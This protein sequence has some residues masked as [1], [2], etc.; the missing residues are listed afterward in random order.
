[1]FTS[2]AALIIGLSQLKHLLGF[3]IPRSHHVHEIIVHAIQDISSLHWITFTIGLGGIFLILGLKKVHKSIPGPLVAVIFGVGL[4]AVL[5][6]DSSGVKIVGDVPGGLP[7]F[8]IPKINMGIFSDLLPAALAIA[9]VSFME[10]IAVA[11]AIQ[12]KHKSY[13]VDPNKELVALGLSNVGGS[14][15]QSYPVTGG[16]SRTAV[17]DQAGA[18]TGMSSIISAVL[19]ILTLLFLTPLFYYL[20]NAILASVIMVAVFGLIDFKEAKHL[21]HSN[22]SDFYMLLVTFITTLAFGIEQGIAAGVILSLAVV[23]FRSSRPHTAV[24]GRVPETNY[25]RNVDRF[26]DLR[27]REDIL[28]LRFDAPLYFANIEY[29]R[30]I[31]E[32]EIREKG[33]ELKAIILPSNSIYEMDSSAASVISDLIDQLEAQNIRLMFSAVRGPVRDAMDKYGLIDKIG[34]ENF[35][36]NIQEAVDHVNPQNQSDRSGHAGYAVQVNE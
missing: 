14:F 12:A 31:F 7:S 24:L 36:M 17:N 4:V 28:I 26:K 19:I 6:L 21:W 27:E 32:D 1:G 13:K 10:S 18:R 2:A 11:K 25:Y 30:N 15:L 20:P 5:G 22:R 29:F 16:F 9:L 34:E 8:S 3:E 35:F 33:D 23:I